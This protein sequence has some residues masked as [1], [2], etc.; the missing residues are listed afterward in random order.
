[1]NSKQETL[2]IEIVFHNVKQR[3]HTQ[4]NESA[5]NRNKHCLWCCA[6]WVTISRILHQVERAINLFCLT[7]LLC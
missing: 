4:R 7:L 2:K 3:K 1:M 5:W 6:E